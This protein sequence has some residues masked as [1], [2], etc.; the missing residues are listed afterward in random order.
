MQRSSASQS[1][2]SHRPESALL[3]NEARRIVRRQSLTR[4]K[5]HSRKRP[6]P[7]RDGLSYAV[8][9]P[10]QKIAMFYIGL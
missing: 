9:L 10:R 8:P 4:P 2:L 5:S 3:G 1:A 6:H 7:E